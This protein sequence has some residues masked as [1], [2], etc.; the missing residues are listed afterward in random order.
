MN[1]ASVQERLI[2]AMDLAGI[3]SVPQLARRSGLPRSYVYKLHTGEIQHPQK[4]LEALCL[5]LD[6]SQVWLATGKGGPY[7]HERKSL[8][9]GILKASVTVV[10]MEG[11][12]YDIDLN[13]PNIFSSPRHVPRDASRYRYFYLPEMNN[14]FPG[15]TL[16]TVEKES[17][18]G[19]GIFLAWNSDRQ[20]VSYK[21]YFN[22]DA[23]EE[24]REHGMEPIGRVRNMD[25]WK[26]DERLN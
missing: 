24:N 14:E 17:T 23:L 11:N 10:P 15:N 19:P 4:H 22:G 7:D 3:T 16:L 21:R 18:P 26:V 12:H 13:V 1:K 9:R 2:T 20:L 8:K 6:V 5:A 25:Y